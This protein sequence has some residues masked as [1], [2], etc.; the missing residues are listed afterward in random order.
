[1]HG[2]G[3]QVSAR[4]QLGETRKRA[5]AFGAKARARQ[6]EAAAARRQ[7]EAYMEAARAC[8][9]RAV[10]LRDVAVADECLE[11]TERNPTM[12]N[13]AGQ[14]GLRARKM[15]DLY[16]LQ[17]TRL[18]HEVLRLNAEADRANSEADTAR[19][20]AEVKP[21]GE[22]PPLGDPPSR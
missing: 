15:A 13:I 8:R 4:K 16:E 9:D 21:P 20:K 6:G 10:A 18:D 19:L 5:T 3:S 22:L 14:D 7:A 2:E 1:M 11:H 12:A 17:A